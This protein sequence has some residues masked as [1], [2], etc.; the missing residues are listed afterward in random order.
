MG[1][2]WWSAHNRHIRAHKSSFHPWYHPRDPPQSQLVQR[3][4]RHTAPSAPWLFNSQVSTA[5]EQERCPHMPLKGVKLAHIVVALVLLPEENWGPLEHVIHQDK[6]CHWHLNSKLMNIRGEKKKKKEWRDKA[7]P[8]SKCLFTQ[9]T[10][11]SDS[12]LPFKC[13]TRTR[14]EFCF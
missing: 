2:E 6:T 5:G 1:V 7:R 4:I 3:G 11:R 12:P 10:F 8:V 9:D 13:D 14:W